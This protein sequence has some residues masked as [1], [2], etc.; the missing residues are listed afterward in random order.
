MAGSVHGLS[1]LILLGLVGSTQAQTAAPTAATVCK[2]EMDKCI[3]NFDEA[4]GSDVEKQCAAFTAFQV[5]Y[6][7][8]SGNCNRW[9]GEL[10]AENERFSKIVMRLPPGCQISTTPFDF[11]ESTASIS[12]DSSASSAIVLPNSGTSGGRTSGSSILFMNWWQWCV[13]GSLCCCLCVGATAAA[14]SRRRRAYGPQVGGYYNDDQYGM[15]VASMQ[16]DPWQAVPIMQP[17]SMVMPQGGQQFQ[18]TANMPTQ[19][20]MPAQN[21]AVATQPNVY[22]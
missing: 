11:S 2:T 6:F 19:F 3:A 5:C 12:S 14:C 4:S 1:L 13:F 9:D 21:Y 22:Y 8:A 20:Q 15:P 7:Q 18:Y 10:D 17:M 16:N